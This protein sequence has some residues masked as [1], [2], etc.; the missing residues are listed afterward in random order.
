MTFRTKSWNATKYH[1]NF[2]EPIL[3]F[4]YITSLYWQKMPTFYSIQRRN[5]DP[6]NAN[7]FAWEHHRMTSVGYNFLCGRLHGAD[8]L[9]RPQASTWAW[10]PPPYERHKWMALK[11][12]FADVKWLEVFRMCICK[13]CNYAS[14]LCHYFY[15]YDSVCRDVAR[16]CF[17]MGVQLNLVIFFYFQTWIIVDLN[18]IFY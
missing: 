8:P 1:C 4:I 9:L 17:L 18:A 6:K 16:R 15:Q 13:Y 2:I 12:S 7:F 10:P 5:F 11:L 14:C 3:L